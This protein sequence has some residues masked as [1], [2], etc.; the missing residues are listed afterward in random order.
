MQIKW[1]VKSRTLAKGSFKR[2]DKHIDLVYRWSL[3]KLL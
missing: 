3:H 1:E 2:I